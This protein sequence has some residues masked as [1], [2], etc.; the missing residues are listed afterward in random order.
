MEQAA[1]DTLKYPMGRFKMPETF[2]DEDILKAIHTIREFPVKVKNEVW[3]LE[4]EGLQYL[5][6]P[7]GWS[8]R[9]IVH[10]CADSHMNAFIR[11]K[12]ALTE[13]NPAIKTYEEAEWAKLPDSTD[14][15]VESSFHVL[16][17]LHARWVNL[18]SAL[19]D[20]QFRRTVFHPGMKK[21]VKV[22]DLLFL[23][24]W[25]CGHHLA[26]IKNAKKY[27]NKF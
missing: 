21:E 16:D 6:R 8:I 13:N 7:G 23:Y 9:Q 22:V 20:A 14:T 17:G 10:H 12:L 24:S 2:T 15:P 5:H 26:H 19:N 1:T 18:L 4:E 3:Y 11:T 25:H 27:K